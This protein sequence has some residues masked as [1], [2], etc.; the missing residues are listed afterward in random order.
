MARFLII[1]ILVTLPAIAQDRSRDRYLVAA[2]SDVYL[3]VLPGAYQ[4]AYGEIVGVIPGGESLQ[5]GFQVTGPAIFPDRVF[6]FDKFNSL[7]KVCGKHL[8]FHQLDRSDS[9]KAVPH[10]ILVGNDQSPNC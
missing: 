9:E 3:V 8:R 1:L 7:R 2:G 6:Y 10:Y 5:A 4:S